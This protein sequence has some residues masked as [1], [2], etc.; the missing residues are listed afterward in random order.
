MNQQKISPNWTYLSIILI[1]MTILITFLIDGV[2]LYITLVLMAIDFY[3][4]DSN[5][6]TDEFLS[7]AYDAKE[8]KRFLIF[9]QEVTRNI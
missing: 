3:L 4:Y 8:G 1:M 6:S 2:F 5:S 9:N 7:V